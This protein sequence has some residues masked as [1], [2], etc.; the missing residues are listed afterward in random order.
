MAATDTQRLL[1]STRELTVGIDDP[2]G[3]VD[4]ENTVPTIVLQGGPDGIDW[5]IGLTWWE[6]KELARILLDVTAV[7]ENG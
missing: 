5:S 4:R 2:Y 6:A 7:A 1:T 3:A